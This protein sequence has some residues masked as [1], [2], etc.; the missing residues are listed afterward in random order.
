MIKNKKLARTIGLI[1][2]GSSLALFGTSNASA[3][4]TTMYNLTTSGGDDNSSNTTDP[5]AN[6]NWALTGNTDGW[7]HGYVTASDGTD[8]ST[9]KWAGTSGINKT[10]FGYTGPHLN[11]GI[12]ITGGHGGTGEI[13][14]FDAFSRYQTYADIDTAKG[15]W[16]DNISGNTGVA[17]GWRHD[18]EFGLFRSDTTGKVTLSAQ[19]I[20]QSGTN[21]GFTIF[22][23][24]N[25]GLTY[26]H[27]GAWNSTTNSNGL[28]NSSL[29]GGG[30]NFDPDG[31]GPQTA[32]G[33]IVAYSV[34]AV[35]SVP[36]SNLNTIQFDA[37]AGQVYTIVL[38]G[39]RNGAW[40]DTI[41]GYR[42]T[43][44]QVPIPA[45]AWMMG[46]GLISL[47]SLSRKKPTHSI[48]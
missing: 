9:A 20:M 35:G 36:A 47:L 5:T 21:F 12:E 37:V 11:W 32:I 42:L 26:G 10:P 43:V 13:S 41:D 45:A 7:I 38:G 46:S 39:Y 15:A 6:G 48:G 2:A 33:Q 8:N 34:G 28:T 25:R 40:D 31:S 4:V 29:P 1:I 22:K 14:T 44:S 23:G 3:T 30:T 17:G 18:L 16:S 24:M 27:H 19:G